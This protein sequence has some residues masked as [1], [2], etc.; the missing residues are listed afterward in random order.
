MTVGR[1]DAMNDRQF[2]LED[3]ETL[4]QWDTATICNA[5]EVIAP[6]RR[7]VGFTIRPVT[8]LYPKM[9]PIIGLA[10]TGTI[11]AREAAR[12]PVA[13]RA[14]WY[15]Y[16]GSSDLP[17]IVVMQDLD[18]HPGLGAFWG[19]MNTTVHR[20]LGSRGTVTNGSFRDIDMCHPEYQVLGGN[21]GPSHAYVHVVDF[22]GPVDVM[23]MHTYHN[24]VI[25]ADVHGAVV[26]PGAC[27]KRLPAAVDLVT[28]RERVVLDFVNGPDFTPEGLREILR[29]SGE[30]H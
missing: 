12:G 28:R 17:T 4:R 14:D 25:H 3:L 7:G 13:H 9:K 2:T 24:D 23:G 10:R 20:R 30:I 1:P 16:V 18:T 22:G 6:E 8:A 15:E 26:I 29:R 27:V 19:E 11:R 21:I 5:L